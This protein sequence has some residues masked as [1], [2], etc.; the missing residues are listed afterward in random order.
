MTYSSGI[1]WHRS[2]SKW[3]SSGN[4]YYKC[5]FLERNSLG[6]NKSWGENSCLYFCKDIGMD[7]HVNIVILGVNDV[8]TVLEVMIV[9]LGVHTVIMSIL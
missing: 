9:V 1:K 3:H 5:A 6:S 7:V 4:Y 2:G 8:C